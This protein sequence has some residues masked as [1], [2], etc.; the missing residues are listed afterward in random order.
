MEKHLTVI[1]KQMCEMAGVDYK[2]IDFKKQSWYSEHEWHPFIE[3]TFKHWMYKYLKTNR[4]AR[5]ELC[6]LPFSTKR[7]LNGVVDEFILQYGW[8]TKNVVQD[9]NGR[10]E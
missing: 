5:K 3:E 7:Y 6:A 2:K 10:I 4:D 8:K 9:L 1:L